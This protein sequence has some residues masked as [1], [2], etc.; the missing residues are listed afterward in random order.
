V[1]HFDNLYWFRKPKEAP[2]CH[3]CKHLKSVPRGLNLVWVCHK[4][5]VV[6]HT[7][8][9]SVIPKP[10]SIEDNCWEKDEEIEHAPEA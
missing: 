4:F 10:I 9:D 8:P 7:P 3:G 6:P 1:G 2:S 5:G